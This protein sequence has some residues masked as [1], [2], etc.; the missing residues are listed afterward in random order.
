MGNFMYWTQEQTN[1]QFTSDSL[2]YMRKEKRNTHHTISF[3]KLQEKLVRV[4]HSKTYKQ[5]VCSQQK[6]NCSRMNFSSLF[7]STRSSNTD[8][9][10]LQLLKVT[11]RTTILHVQ[12]DIVL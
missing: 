11:S 5:Q 12:L 3:D 7:C 4:Y 2:G 10:S 1:L 8:S 6:T 9:D